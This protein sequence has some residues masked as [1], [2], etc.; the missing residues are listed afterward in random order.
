MSKMIGIVGTRRRNAPEDFATVHDAFVK[1]YEPGDRLVSG[2]CPEGGDKFA[3][4]L[5]I[6]LA[7]PGHWTN[8]DLLTFSVARRHHII[9][10]VGAPILIHHAE[11]HKRG[12]GAGFYRNTFIARDADILIACVAE[13]RTGGT[14][15]T[16]GKFLRKEHHGALIL[17]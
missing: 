8:G 14:E 17:C 7:R 4:V 12:R 2:G 1:V 13:D 3:E 10:E 9:K 6:Q 11:W 16:V 15:D 5:A